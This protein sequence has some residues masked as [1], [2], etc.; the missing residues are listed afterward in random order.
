MGTKKTA[1]QAECE[2]I[3]QSVLE[4]ARKLAVESDEYKNCGFR[5]G[6]KVR[7]TGYENPLKIDDIYMIIDFD[8]DPPTPR[9]CVI[10]KDGRKKPFKLENYEDSIEEVVKY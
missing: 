6:S 2:A 5:V 1:E 7:V 3:F 9:L 8:S 10:A 4:R